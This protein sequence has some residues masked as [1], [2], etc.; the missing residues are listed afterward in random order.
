MEGTM[1]FKALFL[2]AALLL[3]GSACDPAAP[4][5][6]SDG[7]CNEAPE[8]P[9]PAAP[10]SDPEP[11]DGCPAVNVSPGSAG[12][13]EACDSSADCEDGMPCDDTSCT[14]I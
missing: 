2:V 10:V 12:F 4:D 7:T 14:C 8:P 1:K 9:P 13:G 5:C 6:V 3:M 11:S